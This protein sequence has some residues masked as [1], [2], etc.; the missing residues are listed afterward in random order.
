MEGSGAQR[1]GRAVNNTYANRSLGVPVTVDVD[2]TR[3]YGPGYA[4]WCDPNEIDPLADTAS[5]MFSLCLKWRGHGEKLV[6]LKLKQLTWIW[7]RQIREGLDP[8]L[9]QHQRHTALLLQHLLESWDE[10]QRANSPQEPPQQ[11]AA[12]TLTIKRLVT[13]VQE[14]FLSQAGIPP[15]GSLEAW[16][17]THSK[18]Y[19]RFIE[20]HTN[21]LQNSLLGISPL[22]HVIGH[23]DHSS[24]LPGPRY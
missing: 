24:L 17:H 13:S 14:F 11:A 9:C 19:T 10:S 12:R 22:K 23:Y 20:Q 8:G 15:T 7:H 5:Q 18:E 3:A 21:L 4:V 2:E 1:K 6:S 16:R